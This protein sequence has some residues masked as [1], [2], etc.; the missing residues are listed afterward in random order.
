ME[1]PQLAAIHFSSITPG[2]IAASSNCEI[3]ENCS[4]TSSTLDA[5]ETRVRR[6][7]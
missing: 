3:I 4:A 6:A 2:N 5:L 7:G 1:H